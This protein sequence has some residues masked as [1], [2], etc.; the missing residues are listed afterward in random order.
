[1]SI[2]RLMLAS[3]VAAAAPASA[4][5]DVVWE[6]SA[7]G[8]YSSGNYGAVE[9]TKVFYA[10]VTLRATSER[11]RFDVAVPY[12]SIEGPQGSVSGG[13]VIPGTGPVTSNSG[14]GDVVVSGAYQLLPPSQKGIKLE[15]GGTVKLPTASDTLGTGE[16]DTSVQLQVTLPL[17]DRLSAIG[18]AGYQWYGNPDAYEL[19]DGAIGSLGLNYATMNNANIGIITN[20]RSSYFESLGD[21]V[22]ASPYISFASAEGW[23]LTGYA[24]AGLTDSSPDFAAGLIVG[25]RFGQR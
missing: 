7:G 12:L 22:T 23:T 3:G 13:V 17:S 11:W 8:I 25:K 2:I 14:L 1:M 10:P 21:Q 9:D 6:V 5:A 4:A 18:S 19:D 24:S 16:T 15:L 20:Y